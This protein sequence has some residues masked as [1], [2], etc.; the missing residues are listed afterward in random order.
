MRHCRAED[1][2]AEYLAGFNIA[3]YWGSAGEFCAELAARTASH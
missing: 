2:R 3:V 1:Y